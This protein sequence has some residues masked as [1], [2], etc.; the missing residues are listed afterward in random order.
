MGFFSKL[1][2]GV[3]SVVKGAAGIVGKLGIP[4]VSGAANIVG[5]L[6][7]EQ[8][9]AAQAVALQQPIAPQQQTFA[10]AATFGGSGTI[11]LGTKPSWLSEKTIIQ[12]LPNWVV[13]IAAPAVVLVVTFM[14]I[15]KRRRR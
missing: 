7:P 3:G 13:V 15:F 4:I 5:G 9:Q 12:W 6:I 11:N 1:V 2:K 8:K 14:L 10:Q